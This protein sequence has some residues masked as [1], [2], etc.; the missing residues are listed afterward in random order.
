MSSDPLDD[1]VPAHLRDDLDDEPPPWPADEI[2]PGLWQSGHPE[3]GEHWDAVFDLSGEEPPLE[4]VEFY[5]HW[6]IED[7]PAPDLD[8]LVALADLVR[9][10]RAAG[11]RVLVHCAA[12]INRSGLLAA[13]SLIREGTDPDDAIATVRAARAGALNNPE[14]VEALRAM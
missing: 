2:V 5:V 10:M 7:G 13:A 6:L 8:T 4:D 1:Y 9:S 12:G 14:F 11:K 3:P